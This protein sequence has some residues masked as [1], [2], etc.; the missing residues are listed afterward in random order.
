MDV[1]EM[2]PADIEVTRSLELIQSITATGSADWREPWNQVSWGHQV[3]QQGWGTRT[4]YSY[5]SS[6]EF[7]VLI[8]YSYSW[9]PKS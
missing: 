1:F 4:R 7:M 3:S 2:L 6:T 9:V 8:L 5:Y